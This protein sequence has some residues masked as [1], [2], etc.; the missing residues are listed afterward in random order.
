[1]ICQA[2]PFS[3]TIVEYSCIYVKKVNPNKIFIIQNNTNLHKFKEKY[4]STTEWR[5][6]IFLKKFRSWGRFHPI[7]SSLKVKINLIVTSL[8][9]IAICCRIDSQNLL[10]GQLDNRIMSAIFITSASEL[11][12]A[13]NNFIFFVWVINKKCFLY[14]YHGYK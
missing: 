6:S 7:N 14:Q 10:L 2:R 9:F 5:S 12:L 11:I 13:F 8:L 3:Q 4:F 1:M